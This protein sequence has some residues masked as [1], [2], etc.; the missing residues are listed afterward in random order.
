MKIDFIKELNKIAIKDKKI[1]FL[2]GD[3]GFNAFEDIRDSLCERFINAG[4]AE[5]NMVSVAAGLAVAGLKPWVHSISS[6]LT[7]KTVEQVRND[8]CHNNLSVKLMGFGGGYG[9]G[10]MGESHHILEDL[11]IYS[12]FPNLKMYI[13]AF[14]EDIP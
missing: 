5:Q 14:L 2:T 7:L 11:A 13:P 8:I 10:I 3:L 6:F 4:V 9:Y 12:S 1:F